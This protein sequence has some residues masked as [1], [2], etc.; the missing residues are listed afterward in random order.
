MSDEEI[1]AEALPHL[2]RLASCESL[3]PM[4]RFAADGLARTVERRTP[5]PVLRVAE[6]A[7][8]DHDQ[9]QPAGAPQR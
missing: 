4:S 5:G 7:G 9:H 2:R 6:S 1:M 8:R 3:H